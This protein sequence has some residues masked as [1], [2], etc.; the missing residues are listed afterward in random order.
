MKSLRDMAQKFLRSK[1]DI[2]PEGGIPEDL[3]EGS[4]RW[5]LYV[6]SNLDLKDISSS[7][8]ALFLEI[9]KNFRSEHLISW[10]RES[11]Q[12]LDPDKLDDL[13]TKV[14]GKL[15]ITQDF[16]ELRILIYLDRVLKNEFYCV[17]EYILQYCPWLETYIV[18]Y[19][20]V[21]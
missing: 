9:T 1:L 16:N 3:K 5:A 15:Q 10:T 7:D 21:E 8:R 20:G 6:Y 14:L 12:E 19:E 18:G 2:L 11:L 13:R 4:Y 17:D